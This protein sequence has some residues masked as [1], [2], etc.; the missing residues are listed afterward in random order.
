MQTA[1]QLQTR[2][3]PHCLLVQYSEARLTTQHWLCSRVLVLVC[4]SAVGCLLWMVAV[5][6]SVS[7]TAWHRSSSPGM[8]PCWSCGW[9]RSW[10]PFWAAQRAFQ[11]SVPQIWGSPVQSTGL[12]WQTRV[13]A[14]PKAAM[15]CTRAAKQMNVILTVTQCGMC[16]AYPHN[17]HPSISHK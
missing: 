11:Q 7:A 4:E 1:S 16:S 5:P 15:T 6:T 3:P 10:V 17:I 14:G 13:A 12:P 9:P 8:H 2:S